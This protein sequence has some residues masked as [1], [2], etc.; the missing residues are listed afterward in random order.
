MTFQL[1][2]KDSLLL[3]TMFD[4]ATRPIAMATGFLLK[5]P[6]FYSHLSDWQVAYRIVEIETTINNELL[7]H[8]L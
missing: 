3:M 2:A 1:K 8:I 6:V 4:F 7:A 5:Q